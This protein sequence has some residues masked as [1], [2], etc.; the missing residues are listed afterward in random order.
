MFGSEYYMDICCCPRDL[1]WL[2]AAFASHSS[3]E[4]FQNAAGYQQNDM[5]M[6]D[7]LENHCSVTWSG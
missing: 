6:G 4:A 7:E 3:A 5:D 1:L 2:T